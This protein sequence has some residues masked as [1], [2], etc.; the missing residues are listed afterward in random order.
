MYKVA[1]VNFVSLIRDGQ[2]VNG[3]S[4]DPFDDIIV[5]SDIVTVVEHAH[6]FKLLVC[7]SCIPT[8]K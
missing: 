1:N 5:P 3:F 7:G 8:L 2:D 4:A 6:D